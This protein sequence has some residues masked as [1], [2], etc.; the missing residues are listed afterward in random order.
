MEEVGIGWQHETLG[1]CRRGHA[2]AA[3]DISVT[4]CVAWRVED[5]EYIC[6]CLEIG[7]F[8]E[9]ELLGHGHIQ[10]AKARR[11][12]AVPT[13]GGECPGARDEVPRGRVHWSV[14][15]RGEKGVARGIAGI[16]TATTSRHAGR[17]V[18][19]VWSS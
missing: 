10:H 3:K 9:V 4:Q 14:A 12:Q 18:E 2:G 8:R 19:V 5:I 15:N 11:V 1:C 17:R 7:S 6:F 13:D 16:E